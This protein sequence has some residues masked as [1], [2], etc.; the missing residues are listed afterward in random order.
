MAVELPEFLNLEFFQNVFEK[1][2]SEKL[3]VDNFWGEFA[4][5]PGD[6]YASDMYRITV[7]YTLGNK[8]NR[9]AVILK[10]N[11]KIYQFKNPH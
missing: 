5:K 6:N 9:K 1:V 8:K 2:Y 7:D 10:V 3:T 4:T 11:T